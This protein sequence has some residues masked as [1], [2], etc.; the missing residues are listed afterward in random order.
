M[1]IYMRFIGKI[2]NGIKDN[3]AENC[4]EAQR[5]KL[6]IYSFT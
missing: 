5:V 4:S 3:F 1:D 6:L 2:L